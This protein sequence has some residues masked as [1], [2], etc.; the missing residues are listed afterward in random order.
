MKNII[1]THNDL[2]GAVSASMIIRELTKYN[3]LYSI[4]PVM[5]LGNRT[6]HTEMLDTLIKSHFS[7]TGNKVFVVDF[8]WHPLADVWI[9]HHKT[10]ERHSPPEARKYLLPM[11]SS[12]AEATT[13]YLGDADPDYVESVNS[14]WAIEWAG[15]IDSA[16]YESPD[17]YFKC[18]NPW[19]VLRL[20]TDHD[21][22]A[23]KTARIAE[24]LA[25]HDFDA[26]IVVDIIG[27]AQKAIEKFQHDINLVGPAIVENGGVGIIVTRHRNDFPRYAEY[28][29]RPDIDFSI[30]VTNTERDKR[31]IRVGH[32]IWKPKSNKDIGRIMADLFPD[33]GGGHPGV[34]GAIVEENEYSD[35]LDKIWAELTRE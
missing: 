8:P 17:E 30:R 34:G 25:H 3:G 6:Y 26:D 24:L 33:S 15:K 13:I 35:S 4:V 7:S 9:D 10:S 1:V 32:N 19:L 12:A 20:F 27:G 11:L 31:E 16:K 5:Y 2:D 21:K 22:Q 29:V 28:I 18:A 23:H 14:T